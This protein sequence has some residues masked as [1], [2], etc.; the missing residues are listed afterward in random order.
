MPFSSFAPGARC[1][2]AG[3]VSLDRLSADSV[4]EPARGIS[5]V[6]CAICGV[7]RAE[8]LHGAKTSQQT[9]DLSAALNSFQQIPI[10]DIIWDR[11][12]Q[13]LATL[14]AA[15]LPMPFQDVLIA[16]VAIENK[17]DLWSFDRHFDA[18]SAVIPS[19]QIFRGPV[20]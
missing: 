3:Y 18:I 15:G 12:G 9:I 6:D 8:I 10:E 19:L 17:L 20:A 4:A 14:R 7:T 11:L 1:D 2:S 5:S 16:T 13:H